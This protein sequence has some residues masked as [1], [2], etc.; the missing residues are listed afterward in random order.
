MRELF[1]EHPHIGIG[2]LW[3]CDHNHI[4][5]RR[6]VCRLMADGFS[7]PPFDSISDH[8]ISNLATDGEPHSSLIGVAG[9]VEN[10]HMPETNPS[11]RSLNT[12]DIC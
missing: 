3:V 1:G 4:H 2:S 10:Q 9:C 12:L 5:A 6:N 7:K 11:S 8:G